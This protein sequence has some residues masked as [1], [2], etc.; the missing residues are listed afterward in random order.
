MRWL[1]AVIDHKHWKIWPLNSSDV[2]RHACSNC[3]IRFNI[4]NIAFLQL[5][6]ISRWKRRNFEIIVSLMIQIETSWWQCEVAYR[7][8]KSRAIV[9]RKSI[10]RKPVSRAPFAMTT[11]A[12]AS[13]H[14]EVL[15]SLYC[16]ALYYCILNYYYFKLYLKNF[17]DA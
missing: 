17:L 12:M 3:R 13:N 15:N 8:T 1:W 11:L 10:F 9:N 6:K 14:F 7:L 2:S 4:F 5:Y 16:L